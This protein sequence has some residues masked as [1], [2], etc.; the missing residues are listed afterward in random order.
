MIFTAIV[1]LVA[2]AASVPTVDFPLGTIIGSNAAVGVDRYAGIPYAIPPLAEKRFKRS[3]L[4]EQKYKGVFDGSK[5]KSPCI[6]N[7]LGNPS[8]ATDPEAPPPSEDCLTLNIWKPS[9]AT[10]RSSFPVMIYIYGGGLCS[11][12]GSNRF[13][14][15]SNIAIQENTIVVGFNYRLGALGYL[16]T[17]LEGKMTGGMNGINDQI[18]AISWVHKY[19]RFFGGDPN[20]VTIFG[21]SSGAYSTCTIAVAPSAKG[22]IHRTIMQSGPCF[23]GP[24]NKGWGPLNSTFGS[25]VTTMILDS[26]NFTTVAQLQQVCCSFF[27][28][29]REF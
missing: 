12:T 11:G 14:N 19:I 22:L 26:F 20:R 1:T 15:G 13:Q 24:P 3:I 16:V 2:A 29:S 27:V 7:P 5:F 4:N 10:S 28:F 18:T 21:Q 23:G 8:E 6:Q 17:D 25:E 9:N